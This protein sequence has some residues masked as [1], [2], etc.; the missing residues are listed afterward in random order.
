MLW[1]GLVGGTKGGIL[2]SLLLGLVLLWILAACA[3]P[4]PE[5]V[6]VEVPGPER[7]VE[8][9]GAERID[10]GPG[11]DNPGEAA[12]ARAKAQYPR[13]SEMRV[14]RM[15]LIYADD[16]QVD[17]RVQVQ[18]PGFCRWYGVGGWVEG[19]RIVWRSGLAIEGITC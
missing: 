1:A 10:E 9:R 7:V 11:L 17:T 2:L 12:V 4:A 5:R 8:V 19:E 16:Q 18:A 13:V 3:T 6:E 14:T 15:I